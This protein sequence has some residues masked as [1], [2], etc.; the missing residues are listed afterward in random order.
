S[1]QPNTTDSLHLFFDSLHRFFNDRYENGSMQLNQGFHAIKE[2]ILKSRSGSVAI[3]IWIHFVLAPD[4]K[5]KENFFN[6]FA[7][8]QNLPE[9]L[10]VFTR[11]WLQNR[12][13]KMMS[14]L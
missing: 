1:R 7:N 12:W 14:S 2:L 11:C 5:Y 13:E 10:P 8:Q 4:S 9:P 3:L 6:Y